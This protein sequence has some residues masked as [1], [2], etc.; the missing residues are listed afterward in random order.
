MTVA[1][2]IQDPRPLP[3]ASELENPPPRPNLLRRDRVLLNGVWR[4]A[5][6]DAAVGRD[7]QWH[8]S[9][10]AFDRTIVVPYPPESA[11]SGIGDER[12]HD[13]VWYQRDIPWEDVRTAGLSASR[14]RLHLHFGAVDYRCTVWVNGTQVGAHEGGHTPF[15]FDITA[16]V[17]AGET[18]TVTVRVEDIAADVE[19]PRGK[20]DWRSEAH[21]IWYRRTSGIWQPV[22]IEA[23]PA[24]FV[25]RVHFTP[26][27]P[28]AAVRVEL[29][30]SGAPS[31]GTACRI[32]LRHRGE[33]IAETSLAVESQR[34]E[35]SIAIPRLRNGQ[36]REG[37]LWSPESP[38]LV[39][40]TVRLHAGDQED[41]VASYL[42]LRSVSVRDGRML[43]N[44]H[45]FLPCAVLSQGFWP[46]SHFAAPDDDALRAEVELIRSLGFNTA[47][48]HQKLEDPRFL[49][50]ADRLG[51]ALWSEMPSA[52]R[53]SSVAVQRLTDE[54]IA[55]L[56]RDRSHPS[57][58][59]WVPF[60]ESWGVQ[61]LAHDAAQ[62]AFVRG[63]VHLTRAVDPSRPVISND[64]WE[65]LE[66]DLLTV[67]DYDDDPA[68]IRAR[69]GRP[70]AAEAL[71]QGIG[72]AGRVMTLGDTRADAPLVL[73]EFGGIEFR[74]GSAPADSWGYSSATN[75]EDFRARLAELY[76]ALRAGDALAGTCYTQLTDTMQE[77]NGLLTEHRE[78]K[79]PVDVIREI[80]TGENG[81]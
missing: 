23:T 28:A 26:E 19:Q 55:A 74:T 68:A 58:L 80:V 44:D 71:R 21:V 11:A 8:L 25:E 38:E 39:D 17:R 27:I 24:L 14:P 73:S 72:P 6:D 79:L 59:V 62:R 67:H 47:R 56:E 22:W 36:D 75:A 78:P 49:Y 30:L 57:I 16:A 1:T 35:W 81:G 66:S 32:E 3:R 50:W 51:L 29:S 43:L 34:E 9:D 69:Y 46:Q 4:F 33:L 61:D 70:D 54:W 20:Q 60:N 42:G 31:P 52:Y 10:E 76:D 40:A 18:Q 63:V 64:G 2:P 12:V 41:E 48:V 77:A 5:Y 7:E 37:I 45:P 15:H 13:V 53:F 65:H